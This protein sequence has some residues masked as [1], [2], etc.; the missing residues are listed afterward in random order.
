[1]PGI[2]QKYKKGLCPNA[3]FLQK[4]M[5]C[6]KTNYWNLDEAREQAKVLRKTLEEYDA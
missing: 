3:E 2:N 4:R 5:I 1:M 6:M